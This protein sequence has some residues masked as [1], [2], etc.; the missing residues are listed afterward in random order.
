MIIVSPSWKL[1]CADQ[2]TASDRAKIDTP[3]DDESRTGAAAS[4]LRLTGSKDTVHRTWTRPICS[5][6]GWSVICQR[7]SGLCIQSRR[8]HRALPQPASSCRGVLGGQKTAIQ[9]LD[10]LDPVLP[11]T[12]GRAEHILDCSRCRTCHLQRISVW[13]E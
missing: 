1:I 5:R 7:R 4:W 3:A 12:P 13:A 9:A 11:F 2:F 8:D 10:R 6:T